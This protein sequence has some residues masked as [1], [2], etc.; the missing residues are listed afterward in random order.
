[1]CFFWL[2]LDVQKFCDR[3]CNMSLALNDLLDS[4]N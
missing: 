2:A 4:N 3:N 1:M